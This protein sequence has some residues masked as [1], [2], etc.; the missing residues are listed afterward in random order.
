MALLSYSLECSTGHGVFHSKTI[1]VA[2]I[3]IAQMDS[4]VFRIIIYGSVRFSTQVI[5]FTIWFQ[6]H[7]VR[8]MFKKW[9][10]H[11]YLLLTHETMAIFSAIF[12][13][14]SQPRRIYY[15]VTYYLPVIRSV[16]YKRK[17]SSIHYYD[18][19]LQLSGL[20]A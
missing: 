12:I 6:A 15:A 8:T 17:N 1:G 2:K 3:R 9:F 7:N 4:F 18:R 13:I 14:S 10:M 5:R 16:K 19:G 11:V 20:H